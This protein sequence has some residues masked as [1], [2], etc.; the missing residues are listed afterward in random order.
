MK[1]NLVE[2]IA[3]IA[4]TQSLLLAFFLV[5]L[6][7]GSGQSNKILAILLFIF[8]IYIA[9]SLV[10]SKPVSIKYII[11]AYICSQLSL[12]IGPFI[13]FYFNSIFDKSF[14]FRLQYIIHFVP[15]AVIS[16]YLLIIFYILDNFFYSY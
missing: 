10:I 6:K 2:V 9:S 7:K 3:I 14:H 16:I 15:F 11:I 13:Y 5:T 8:V 4:I 1:F 12:L